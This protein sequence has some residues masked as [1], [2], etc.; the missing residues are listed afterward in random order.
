MSETTGPGDA[1]KQWKN[2]NAG[3]VGRAV[4]A[5]EAVLADKSF[6]LARL[7]VAQGALSDLAQR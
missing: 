1:W 2:A 7:A 5:V 3:A 6:D 4:A